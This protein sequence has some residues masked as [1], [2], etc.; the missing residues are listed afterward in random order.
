MT[1]GTES[2][3]EHCITLCD[4]A[5]HDGRIAADFASDEDWTL[6]GQTAKATAI[7]LSVVI[8]IS[9]KY[10]TN[11]LLSHIFSIPLSL[12]CWREQKITKSLIATNTN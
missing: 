3:F 1:S 9:P 2:A 4:N 12:E 8:I 11:I 7:K 5:E 6:H 10:V